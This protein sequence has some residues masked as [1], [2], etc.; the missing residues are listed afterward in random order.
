VVDASRRT[1]CSAARLQQRGVNWEPAPSVSIIVRTSRA[2]AS[3]RGE[4]GCNAATFK[5][6]SAGLVA[7]RAG[8]SGERP[9][10]DQ[11]DGAHLKRLCEA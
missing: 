5:A 6:H 11:M 1:G 7:K 3:P 2:S 8:G 4:V 9:G 10:M